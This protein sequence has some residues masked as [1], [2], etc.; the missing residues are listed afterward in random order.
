M[1][2]KQ[3]YLHDS[4]RKTFEAKIQ[5]VNGNEGTLDQTI[6]HPLT[7]GVANDTGDLVIQGVKRRVLRVEINRETKE[8]TH[9]LEDVSR[10]KAGDRVKGEGDWE[11]RYKLMR[12]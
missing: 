8:I 10:L 1:E 2:T 9:V 4:Y 5:T 12:L 6:F 11:R 3:L 7:G